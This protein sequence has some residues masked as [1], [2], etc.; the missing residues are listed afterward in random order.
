LAMAATLQRDTQRFPHAS[1]IRLVVVGQV[2][3]RYMQ[4]YVGA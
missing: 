1:C 2:F 4:R 3:A